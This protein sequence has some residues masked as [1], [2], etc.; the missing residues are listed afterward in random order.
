M[1]PS[2]Q[3]VT[4]GPC[5]GMYH[6][7][8]GDTGIVLLAPFGVEA[9][10]CHKSMRLLAED[11][12]S[13]GF[14]TLRFDFPGTGDSLGDEATLDAIDSRCKSALA[15][16]DWLKATSGVKNVILVGLRLG[17]SIAAFVGKEAGAQRVVLM[18]PIVSGKRYVR[19]MRSLYRIAKAKDASTA[20]LARPENRPDGTTEASIAPLE[21]DGFRLSQMS[22]DALNRMDL[23]SL[24]P[25]AM[26]IMILAPSGQLAA[27]DLGQQ[28]RTAGARVS[29]QD[30]LGFN[31]LL[32]DPSSADPPR[33]DLTQVADWIGTAPPAGSSSSKRPETARLEGDAFIETAAQ[34]GTGN[35]VFGILCRAKQMLAAAPVLIL[36]N[37][38]ANPHVG[39]GRQ[40]VE[41]A[42]RLASLGISTLRI[43]TSGI[44]ETPDLVDRPT[45]VFYV[46]DSRADVTAAVDWLETQGIR[47]PALSGICSGA[48]LAFQAAAIE[49]RLTAV[50]MI[51]LQK[52]VWDASA[53]LIVYSSVNYY[54]SMLRQ[55]AIWLRLLKGDVDTRGILRTI[56]ERILR[57]VRTRF[58]RAFNAAAEVGDKEHRFILDTF[59]DF[60][61][62]GLRVL[63]AY[64]LG[65][66]GI[67][68]M[69]M[70]LGRNG[71]H[72]TYPS[73]K[74]AQVAALDH[75]F[76]SAE[77]RALLVPLLHDFILD[78]VKNAETQQPP[79]NQPAMALAAE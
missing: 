58:L 51:N 68:E 27:E 79:K 60:R 9:L 29:L 36:L 69:K 76:T 72:I 26:D 43:D 3:A 54:L 46:A 11:C 65:D 24:P 25:P 73:F 44:G 15:A 75:N 77:D 78:C 10:A 2:L 6:E 74:F 12:A 52:F 49:P 42:R 37:T 31:S 23:K 38:G 30:F 5:F 21:F 14:P 13:R 7:A 17:A 41:I 33:A 4:F 55:P 70:Q 67:D 47:N 35:Q 64:S 40:T 1:E 50:A 20:S 22:F 16:I 18:A 62:R 28:W 61:R 56:C 32:T 71:S 66:G 63:M 57:V 53:R 39:W 34:F 8:A 48:Y 59:A 45:R 19:E